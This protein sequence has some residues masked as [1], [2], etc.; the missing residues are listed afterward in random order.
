MPDKILVTFSS[1]ILIMGA[2]QGV[3][4]SILLV[5]KKHQRRSIN[6]HL[7]IILLA[8]SAETFHLFLLKTNYINELKILAGFSLP[9]DGVIAIS[10][11]WY[12]RTITYPEKNNTI[13]TVILHYL[14][15]FVYVLLTI[16][17]WNLEFS[18]QINFLNTGAL[19]SDWPPIIYNSVLL[20]SVLKILFFLIYLTLSFNLL[21]N[22]KKRIRDV[23]S[24]NENITLSWLT[25]LLWLFLFGASQGLIL[26]IF[27]QEPSTSI[28]VAGSLETFTLLTI[29]YIGIMGLLQPKIYKQP[30]RIYLKLR[31]IQN[32]TNQ[33][34]KTKYKKSAL[35]KDDL[36]R[37]SGKIEAIMDSKSLYLDA[38]LTLPKLAEEL[39]IAPHYLSQTFS[40]TLNV[41]FFDYINSC[42][43]NYA[44]QQLLDGENTTRT[45][46][47]IATGS[48]FN[49]R[50]AFYSAFK[51]HVGMTPAQFRE[52][53]IK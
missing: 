50:S 34:I 15:F 7:S 27:F 18:Q 11:Y 32:T 44:K 26:L 40:T 21:L 29:M 41:S 43:I 46:A 42:R 23:F 5:F 4:F 16:P 33:D 22:H 38:N 52:I 30:E 24:Y 28:Q 2:F 10:L 31:E 1:L 19:S 36:K 17:F 6:L 51:K 53:S 49:S 47:D 9:F 39:K 37:I 25:N 12:V 14:P 3:L 13:K 48:A 45:I 35:S 8:L 20:Q